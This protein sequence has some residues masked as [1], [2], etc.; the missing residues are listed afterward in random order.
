MKTFVV[1]GCNGYIGSHMC[2]ELG[3][4]Y[5]DC[6]IY[7]IDKHDKGHLRHLYDF[8]NHTDLAV[9]PISIPEGTDAIFHF[10]AYIGVEEGEQQP[11]LY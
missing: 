3:K 6:T 5:N 7:G 1:T 2:S 11:S 9:D 8:Y 4:L 10:A